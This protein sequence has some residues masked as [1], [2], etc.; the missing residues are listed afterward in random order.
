M[1]IVHEL[2]SVLSALCDSLLALVKYDGSEHL[3]QIGTMPQLLIQLFGW[4]LLACF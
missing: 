1:L 2:H 4:P 3:L